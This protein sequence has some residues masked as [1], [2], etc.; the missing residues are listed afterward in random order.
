MDTGLKA[1]MSHFGACDHESL[2]PDAV[3]MLPGSLSVTSVYDAQAK[4]FY[5][6]QDPICSIC[7][8][9]PRAPPGSHLSK[10]LLSPGQGRLITQPPF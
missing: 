10:R 3:L 1:Q 2:G 9:N 7:H 6:L 4:L 8:L 5:F